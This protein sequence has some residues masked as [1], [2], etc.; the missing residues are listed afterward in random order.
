MAEYVIEYSKIDIALSM[1]VCV[2]AKT[3]D[4]DGKINDV[5]NSLEHAID[6]EIPKTYATKEQVAILEK[7]IS[8]SV[9]KKE[10]AEKLEE[11]HTIINT[12][13]FSE[14]GKQR[15]EIFH[16]ISTVQERLT[17]EIEE[18]ARGDELQMCVDRVQQFVTDI[19]DIG[20][21][22]AQHN[23]AIERAAT[24]LAEMG[25]EFEGHVED[26]RQGNT[27][28]NMQLEGVLSTMNDE[29]AKVVDGMQEALVVK[30]V[31]TATEEA[32]K[33]TKDL[34]AQIPA[35]E[36]G[37]STGQERKRGTGSNKASDSKAAKGE[38]KGD[39]KV[40]PDSAASAGSSGVEAGAAD[41]FDLG[42]LSSKEGN[43]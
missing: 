42:A 41:D 25:S 9:T 14:L 16:K 24:N 12:F 8:E 6:V 29:I 18:I 4:L 43:I 23:D 32:L 40:R 5:R 10:L 31:T 37:A 30:A 36:G 20:V 28:L 19:E 33:A 35:G 21:A 17:S 11:L 27:E 7:L 1:N 38:K 34:I 15:T 39:K 13:V 26:L 2:Q 22:V 3:E